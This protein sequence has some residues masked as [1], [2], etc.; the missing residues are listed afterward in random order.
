MEGIVFDPTNSNIMY[1]CGSAGGLWKTTNGGDNWKPIADKLGRVDGYAVAVD[2]SDPDIVYFGTGPGTIRTW[3]PDVPLYKS[4]DGG[5]TWHLFAAG[6]G[7]G[8]RKIKVC[9]D[10]SNNVVVYLATN[11]GLHRYTNSDPRTTTSTS[12][13]WTRIHTGVIQD[14]VLHPTDSKKV[15]ISVAE[16]KRLNNRDVF[17]HE[18]IYRTDKGYT[19]TGDNDWTSI[20]SNLPDLSNTPGSSGTIDLYQKTPTTI[21]AS[22]RTPGGFKVAKVSIYKSLYL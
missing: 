9:Y 3:A 13:D 12:S 20:S 6:L 22:L 2:P 5:R 8:T 17:V 15:Y 16:W 1:V 19:A 10:S 21:Y 11:D 4:I 18:G 14:L 7:E